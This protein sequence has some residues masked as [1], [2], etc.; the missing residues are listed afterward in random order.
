MLVLITLMALPGASWGQEVTATPTPTS[1]FYLDTP[2]K[3]LTITSSRP[4]CWFYDSIEWP[5]EDA[6]TNPI[7]G[8]CYTA[9]MQG[10][11]GIQFAAMNMSHD[12]YTA[13]WMSFWV[14]TS[15][16]G[17]GTYHICKTDPY[18]G[19]SANTI[20]AQACPGAAAGTLGSW[21]KTVDGDYVATWKIG[22]RKSGTL[23][24]SN[25][26]LIRYGIPPDAATPTPIPTCEPG[27]ALVQSSSG[28][29]MDNCQPPASATPTPTLTATPTLTPTLTLT[30]TPPPG[31]L[32]V[33][34][35]VENVSE[36]MTIA[37]GAPTPIP[38][39]GNPTPIPYADMV[40]LN[41]VLTNNSQ[42]I[43]T[44]WSLELRDVLYKN[45]ANYTDNQDLGYVGQLDGAYNGVR[46]RW[47]GSQ[48]DPGA[49]VTVS[50]YIEGRHSGPLWASYVLSY[51]DSTG[52]TVTSPN[53][54][55]EI[56]GADL[57]R[58]DFDGAQAGLKAA[59]FWVIYNE[60]SEG[61]IEN[62]A[63]S[64]VP[65]QSSGW[66][67]DDEREIIRVIHKDDAPVECQ[68]SAYFDVQTM[69]NG[70]L[71]V[72]R[73]LP[74]RDKQQYYTYFT[75]NF[76]G[77]LGNQPRSPNAWNGPNYPSE[78]GT[79]T[80]WM[81]WNCWPSYT[82][83]PDPITL[84]T[85]REALAIGTDDVVL[86][87]LTYYANCMAEVWQNTSGELW[88]HRRAFYD[89]IYGNTNS[90]INTAIQDYQSQCFNSQ[91]IDDYTACD[92]TEGSVERKFASIDS[93]NVFTVFIS[94][95]QGDTPT[96]ALANSDADVRLGEFMSLVGS[97]EYGGIPGAYTPSA[98]TIL[99]PVV[100]FDRYE[101]TTDGTYPVIACYWM[102]YAYQRTLYPYFYMR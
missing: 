83:D 64:S 52:Q 31:N 37:S 28:D 88:T 33:S 9:V 36:K 82:G 14:D 99:Y 20:C 8:T 41:A 44:S 5:D 73:S 15:G 32:E 22:C 3:N 70:V 7:V 93:G 42:G 11:A 96:Q 67:I 77:S 71:N 85:Y 47:T 6:A 27:G 56:F 26:G 60:T 89:R 86:Y 69:I 59:M 80:L 74:G 53:T 100:F 54:P 35:V 102:S 34:F 72:D 90:V 75:T 21:P 19:R 45:T 43:V 65:C 4:T 101:N 10:E 39:A 40:K 18:Q 25:M 62:Y 97:P 16:T 76:G 12:G 78:I 79:N 17:T 63:P 84:L 30:P 38:Y 13:P 94:N 91:N 2:L 66:R 68:E 87:W 1:Q 98:S 81:N 92:P 95:C 29:A 58:I 57:D 51:T 61:K 24:I 46:I 49:S 23:T 55:I 50:E 48:V